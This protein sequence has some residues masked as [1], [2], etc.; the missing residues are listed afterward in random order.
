ML[1]TVIVLGQDIFG[2]KK[3]FYMQK[4]IYK[5]VGGKSRCEILK[6]RNILYSILVKKC[7]NCMGHFG[8]GHSFRSAKV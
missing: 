7:S 4:L 1:L 3:R 8:L 2:K 5:K 6:V